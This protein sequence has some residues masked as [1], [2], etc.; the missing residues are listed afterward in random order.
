[1]PQKNSVFMK[2]ENWKCEWTLPVT[3]EMEKVRMVSGIEG[4]GIVILFMQ[5]ACCSG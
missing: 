4:F 5:V 2:I 1:M 3:L